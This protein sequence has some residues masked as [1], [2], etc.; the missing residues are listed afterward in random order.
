[1]VDERIRHIIVG[2]VV[3]VDLHAPVSEA[4]RLFASR[5]LHHL[6]VTDGAVLKG[7][8]SSADMLK[9]EHFRPRGGAAAAALLDQHFRIE[10]LMRYPVITAVPDDTIEVAASRMVLHGVHALPVVDD[11]GQLLGIV[12]TSDI[13]HALLHGIGVGASGM[14]QQPARRPGELEMRRA[15]QAAEAAVLCGGDTDGVA[16]ALLYLH[17]RNGLLET[18]RTQIAR[19]LRVGQDERLHSSL[20]RQL[21]RCAEPGETTALETPL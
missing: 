12:T 11:R 8:L 21:E 10:T 6:P 15:L 13:M 16:T 1:M 20:H 9:L 2:D 18:L 3:S 5:P 17:R 19:Y 7:M 14:P 4:M